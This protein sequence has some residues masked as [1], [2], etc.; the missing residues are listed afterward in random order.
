MLLAKYFN[1]I[2]EVLLPQVHV[3]HNW[4]MQF[5]L[6]GMLQLAVDKT[7]GLGRTR[8]VLVG[9]WQDMCILL[10]PQAPHLLEL[11]ESTRMLY[12]QICE[13]D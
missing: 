10:K 2:L 8:G 5:W 11:V 4:I 3:E 7:I 9:E 1:Y 12:I 13:K 6:L